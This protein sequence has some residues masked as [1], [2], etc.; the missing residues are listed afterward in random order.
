MKNILIHSNSLT[1]RG[2]SVACYDYAFYLRE[3]LKLNPIIVYNMNL[4]NTQQSIERFQKDFV[5]IGYKSFSE[6]QKLVDKKNIDYFYAIKYGNKDEVQVKNCKNL[7]HSVFCSNI[8]EIHGDKYAVVSEWLSYKSN[9]RIPN[10]SHMINLP[11]HNEDYRKKLNIPEDSTVIGRYGGIDTFDIDFVFE[12]VDSILSKRSNIWFLFANT[13]KKIQHKRCL[14]FDT[15]IN[16]HEK[17]KFIN[18]CDAFLHARSYGETFGLSV[19]EFSSKNKQ[20]ITY[21]NYDL[22]NNHPLGG[23]N[24]FLYLKENCHTYS[25]QK[26]LDNIFLN[27][28]RNNPFNTQYLNEEFSPQSVINKFKEVFL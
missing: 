8:S 12:S 1:E 7:I 27:I 9:Y 5:V 3:Y 25:N 22:Q 13:E 16:L 26:D 2:V 17:V 6:V 18:T 10:I 4:E 21:D 11:H 24:H 20:I 15:I 23:R 28:T 19:L 14:Y